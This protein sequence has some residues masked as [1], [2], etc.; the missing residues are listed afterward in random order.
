MKKFL[1]VLI[2]LGLVLCGC[3]ST[4]NNSGSQNSSSSQSATSSSGNS[5]G[6]TVVG[7]WE[8][9]GTD[10]GTPY[11]VNF[12]LE[13]DGQFEL[14]IERNDI[15]SKISG[16]YVSDDKAITLS[17]VT[18]EDTSSTFTGTEVQ[19]G[20]VVLDYSLSNDGRSLDLHN[21]NDSVSFLPSPLTLTKD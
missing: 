19:N 18:V 4:S 8:Y 21:A 6:A 11:E 16:T 13:N 15:D 7:D 9:H 10:N 17:I 14:E 5:S 20:Q 1:I 2:V 12:D 3:A